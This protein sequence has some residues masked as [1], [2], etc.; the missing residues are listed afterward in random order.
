MS[1]EDGEDHSTTVFGATGKEIAKQVAKDAYK[2]LVQPGAKQLG[3]VTE[4]IG[5]LINAALEPLRQPALMVAYNSAAT[6]LALKLSQV[7]PD[8]LVPPSTKLAVSTLE[9]IG[10]NIDEAELREMFLNLLAAS[11]TSDR[12][13]NVHPAFVSIIDQLTPAEA[14]VLNLFGK[15]AIPITRPGEL[16]FF[17][18]HG[19]L[20]CHLLEDPFATGLLP[21]SAVDNLLRSQLVS[22]TQHFA[23]VGLPDKIEEGISFTLDR[24]QGFQPVDSQFYKF[25]VRLSAK[26]GHKSTAPQGLQARCL[27]L[28]ALGRDLCSVCLSRN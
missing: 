1:T 26:L 24:T 4:T 22:E 5:L 11:M 2:D 10:R 9:A 19:S 23:E 28:T 8:G 18:I 7:P 12:A 16:W 14:L 20:A 21:A 17:D 27:R 3:K 13:S 15:P 25:L 6:E